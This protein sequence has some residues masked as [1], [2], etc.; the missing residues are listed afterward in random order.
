MASWSSL[1]SQNIF[2]SRLSLDVSLIFGCFIRL[3]LLLLFSNTRN[4]PRFTELASLAK[5]YLITLVVWCYSDFKM[6]FSLWILFLFSN[7]GNSP[8]FT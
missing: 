5:Y 3:W 8:D 6:F 4:S 1:R 2:Q 7:A